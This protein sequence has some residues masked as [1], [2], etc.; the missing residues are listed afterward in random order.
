MDK[1]AQCSSQ[2]ETAS[3]LLVALLTVVDCGGG[4]QAPDPDAGPT[5]DAGPASLLE[6]PP[7]GGGFQLAIQPFDVPQ[8]AEVQKCYFVEVPSDTDIWVNRITLALRPGSH[9]LNVFRVRTIKNLGGSPGEVVTD[10]ECFKSANW[11]DWPLVINSQLSVEGKN[12]NDWTLPTGVAH[13]FQARELLMVQTH[14][15]NATTQVTPGV[16]EALVNF[17]LDRTTPNPVELGTVFATNQ[18]IRVCPGA[19]AQTF[20]ASC[21]FARAPVT[22]VGAN[23]HF[24]SRGTDFQIAT[25]DPLSGAGQ[26]FYDNSSW[27]DPLFQRDLSIPIEAGGGISYT[28]EYTASPSDCGDPADSCCFTFGAKVEHQEHCNAFVYY[29][30]K[31]TDINCF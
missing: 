27:S 6:P 4:T 31:Q 19:A 13:K 11:S 21:R 24:H 20:T 15:V 22:I 26:P 3:F 8:G 29:Y 30:P 2:F 23:G 12:I 5:P 1:R 10:G 18:N 9:H 25:W 28:C 17:Y 14:F 7:T 16:G